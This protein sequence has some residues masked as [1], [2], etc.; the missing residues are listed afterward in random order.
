MRL[1]ADNY[2]VLAMVRSV[3]RNADL[4]D[5]T[6]RMVE[7]LLEVPF[8]TIRYRLTLVGT[9]WEQLKAEERERRLR[10]ILEAPG[11]IDPVTAADVV[12]FRELNSFYRFFTDRMGMTYTDWR[13]QR[14]AA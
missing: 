8:S 6:M 2:E 13:L 1:P 9:T 5:C 4:S 11:R 14:Q 3:L 12:G 10:M 7:R